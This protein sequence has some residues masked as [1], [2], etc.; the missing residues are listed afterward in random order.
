MIAHRALANFFASMSKR[1]GMTQAD[2][3]LAV[4]SFSFDIAALELLQPLLL[5]AC[6]HIASQQV[7]TDGYA[8][9]ALL[10]T[11][12]ATILQ[13]TPSTW[14]M[15]LLS[16]WQGNHH[17]KMLCGGEALP[18]DLAVQLQQRGA[19]LWN[20]YGP[21]ETTIWSAIEDLS[22]TDTG[23]SIGHG[24]DNTQL[25]VLDS[26]GALVPIGGVGELYIA[27]EGLAYGYWKRP[28]ISAE[29]FL[30]NP[31]TQQAGSRMYR[32]G[33]QVRWLENGRL[34]YLGR[35]D[36]QVKLRGFRIEP[37]EIEIVLREHPAVQEAVV[38]LREE[39]AAHKYLA[40]YIV[41]QS[42]RQPT[43]QELQAHLLKHLPRYMVPASFVY[44][45]ALPLTLNGKVHRQ[46][47]PAPDPAQ[48]NLSNEFV[49]PET[50]LQ[51]QLSEIWIELLHLPQ[52]GIQ[53]NFFELGGHSLLATRLMMR[54]SS[55]FLVEVPLR[56]LFTAPTIAQLALVIEQEQDKLIEQVDY[57]EV[58]RMLEA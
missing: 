38:I 30:P 11:S 9:S 21:T 1:P 45:E 39:N 47:L 12:G 34:A 31:F 41:A 18:M 32:T 29:R 24:I 22:S 17:I 35:R 40:A 54:I 7:T 43:H 56:M 36:Q 58:I 23:I 51:Q 3:V 49:A 44:L 46:A 27:G 48:G 57:E 8:L 50:E 26:R 42:D 13:A 5:G 15:L 55:E 25:Y 14:E 28:D 6:I 52:V 19:A 4:T 2:H 10:E 16:G 20:M 33:D 37:G 53:D